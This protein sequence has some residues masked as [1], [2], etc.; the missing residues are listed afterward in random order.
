[1]ALNSLGDEKQQQPPPVTLPQFALIEIDQGGKESHESIE[2]MGAHVLARISHT[3]AKHRSLHG[4]GAF[5]RRSGVHN[6]CR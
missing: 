3:A 5:R 6:R 2:D 4:A 1:M